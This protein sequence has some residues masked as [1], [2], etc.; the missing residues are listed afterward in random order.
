MTD[1]EVKAKLAVAMIKGVRVVGY[2]A[3]CYE[4]IDTDKFAY[5]HDDRYGADERKTCWRSRDAGD[6]MNMYVT[7]LERL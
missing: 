3:V 5:A 1:E 7:T 6:I 2:C 4:P